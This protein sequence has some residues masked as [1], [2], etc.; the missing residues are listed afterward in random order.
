MTA[1]AAAPPRAAASP[2]R[3]AVLIVGGALLLAALLQSFVFT[4]DCDVSWMF[5]VGDAVL[6]GKRLYVDIIEVNPPASPWLYLPMV[7]LAHLAGL[8]I[9]AVAGACTLAAATGSIAAT[10]ALANRLKRA[11]GPLLF[12]A[13]LA[14]AALVLPATL[15]A[16]REHFALLLALPALTA[17]ALVADGDDARFMNEVAL[18]Q[19]A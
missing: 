6:A 11:P 10:L 4:I 13:A 2:A 7:A 19:Q 15:F 18:R 1:I 8:R 16:Q 12:P 3:P 14:F 17:L 9:E 5:T